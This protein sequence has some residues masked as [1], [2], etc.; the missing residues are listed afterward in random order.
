MSTALPRGKRHIAVAL[1]GDRTTPRHCV[2]H[3]GDVYDLE[4]NARTLKQGDPFLHELV[5]GSDGYM[6][7]ADPLGF[8]PHAF[9]HIDRCVVDVIFELTLIRQRIAA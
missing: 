1:S 2:R 9:E 4:R 8:P 7:R 6:A 3:F 5:A